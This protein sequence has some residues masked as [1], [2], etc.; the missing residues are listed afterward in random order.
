MAVSSKWL[1]PGK[2]LYA[3]FS[4][5]M[6]E[7]DITYFSKEQ[8][9]LIEQYPDTDVFH[10]IVDA[11]QVSEYPR[12]IAALRAYMRPFNT[13][14]AGWFI[15]LT[16]DFYPQHLYS[17][18]MRIMQVRSHSCATL[19]EAY[20]FLQNVDSIPEP[21]DWPDEVDDTMPYRRSTYN[22]HG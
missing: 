20:Q 10:Y 4:G 8:A 15:L 18:L 12:N 17:L 1:I 16:T 22:G 3:F 5:E 21:D 2:V 14:R 9:K 11:T 7:D 19:S 6:L 13:N